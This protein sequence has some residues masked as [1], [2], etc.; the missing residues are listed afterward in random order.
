MAAATPEQ[1]DV[2][3]D[4]HEPDGCGDVLPGFRLPL[5]DSFDKAGEPA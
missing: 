5:Q 3:I 4:Q 2:P 1:L